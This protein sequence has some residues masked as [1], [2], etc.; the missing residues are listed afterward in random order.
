MVVFNKKHIGL[1]FT[2]C[3]VTFAWSAFAVDYIV[4]Y[5][6]SDA[7]SN[8]QNGI[9]SGADKIILKYQGAGTKWIS[10]PLT[11]KSNIEIFLE[12]GVILE[13]KSGAFPGVST[14]LMKGV[15]VSNF[16]ITGYGATVR[17]LINEY[18][19]G[20]WRHCIGFYTCSNVEVKGITFER[21]GGD[22]IY[23]GVT[24]PSNPNQNI[25]IK[26]VVCDGNGRQGISVISAKNLTIEDCTL[27]NTGKYN[28][29]GLAAH[30]PWAGIDFEMNDLGNTFENILVKNCNFEGN[31]NWGIIFAAWDTK[32]FSISVEDCYIKNSN[33]G[34]K[35]TCPSNTG[36]NNYLKVENTIIENTG[37][38]GIYFENWAA[39]TMTPVIKNC[40]IISPCT[41]KDK[42][43]INIYVDSGV[44][45]G[46][47]NFD[48]V[49][50][51]NTNSNY[52]VT[53][54]GENPNDKVANL[55]GSIYFENPIAEIIYESLY[56]NINVSVYRQ[57]PEFS[58]VFNSNVDSVGGTDSEGFFTHPDAKVYPGDYNGD[59]KTD[60][61]VKGYG[62]YRALYLANSQGNGFSRVFMGEMDG[63]GGTHSDGRL[64][65]PD[66]EVFPGDYN[67]DGKTDLFVKGYGTYRTLYL[68][69]S[70]GTGFDIAFSSSL[71]NVGGTHSDGCLTSSDAKVYTGDYNGDGKTDLFVKGYGTYRT[72]Y[73]AN[74]SGTGFDVAF[75]SASDNVGGTDSEGFFTDSSAKIYTGDYNG[76][77]KTDLFI[78][79]YQKYRALYVANESGNGFGRLFY[80][81]ADSIGGTDSEDFF[82]HPDAK[83]YSGDYTGDGKT[84]LFVKGFGNYRALYV[85]GVH[86]NRFYRMFMGDSAGIGGTSS[87][88]EFTSSD[89]IVYPGDYN[90]DG[91]TDLFLKGYQTYRSLYLMTNNYTQ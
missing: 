7:T 91:K 40:Q 88:L 4:P 28:P 18:T 14:P 5:N 32:G 79:G 33:R 43:A 19:S 23:L 36:T 27:K 22:G 66:A 47:I 12:S 67:G 59:G 15:D 75:S 81:N 62:T 13:A 61:F 63:I 76:D 68:A 58:E 8:I 11:L 52:A 70:T 48:N 83:I 89:A 1:F 85:A 37:N 54:F 26:D 16:K 25:V 46:D 65:S 45:S 77:G 39:G 74:S 56:Q 86:G 69:N 49:T 21:S 17:M 60:L 41:V 50:V 72:L 3:I 2:V 30:G 84:D 73:L 42:G 34:I 38:C 24:G 20:E 35:Y 57:Y 6:S 82:T 44:L 29:A 80:G 71:D 87:G 90:G 53:L 10:G 78:K 64:T 55:S 31:V 9:N 51:K